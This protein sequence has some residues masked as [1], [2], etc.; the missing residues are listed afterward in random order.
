MQKE[1]EIKRQELSPSSSHDQISGSA[2]LTTFHQRALVDDC[3][4]VSMPKHKQKRKQPPASSAGP[5]KKLKPSHQPSQPKANV[6]AGQS[7]QQDCG[8]AVPFSSKD[9]V[10]LLGEGDFSF[11]RCLVEH[12]GGSIA[13]LTATSLDPHQDVL[14]KYPHASAHLDFLTGGQ[15]QDKNDD[16]ISDDEEEVFDGFSPPPPDSPSSSARRANP[17]VRIAHGVDATRLDK[18]GRAT[19]NGRGGFDWAVF[20]FPHVGGRSTDVNRQV[21]ANQQLLVG[22]FEQAKKVLRKPPAQSSAQNTDRTLKRRQA[23]ASKAEYDTDDEMLEDSDAEEVTVRRTSDS[24]PGGRILVTLFEGAPYSLWNIRDLARH[25]GL[26]VER[27]WKFRSSDFPGYAHARTLGVVR[28]KAERKA[29]EQ[30]DDD[31][32]EGDGEN[33]GKEA[34]RGWRGEDR[35]ARSYVFFVKAWEEAV[36]ANAKGPGKKRKGKGSDSE[37]DD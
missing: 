35:E 7:R 31:M 15:S 13:I 22:F 21:R 32:S 37:S 3:Y 24:T 18:S 33:G 6:N 26:G 16:T 5:N 12:H 8:P 14:A 11:A 28:S 23:Q 1:E 9:D 2:R 25:A 4:S 19:K 20:M 27:S 30:A 10:L 29:K 36:S 34:R 17:R